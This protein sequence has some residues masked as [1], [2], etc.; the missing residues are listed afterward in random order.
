L[1][2]LKCSYE[3]Y[4]NLSLLKTF[5]VIVKQ[6]I[7]DEDVAASINTAPYFAVNKLGDQEVKLGLS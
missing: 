5:R 3:S 4:E 1:I 2:N 7:T 6:N